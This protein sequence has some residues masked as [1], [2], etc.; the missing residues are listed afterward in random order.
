M[1]TLSSL[2]PNALQR[3]RMERQVAAAQIVTAVSEI[4]DA[5]FPDKTIRGTFHI[6]SVRNHELF[7]DCT[8]SAVAH[9]VHL[10]APEVLKSLSEVYPSNQVLEIVTRVASSPFYDVA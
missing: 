7:V 10:Y 5:F 9:A 1:Q 6:R 8:T 3:N 4:F 2:L